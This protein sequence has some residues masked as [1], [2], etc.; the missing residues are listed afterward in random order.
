MGKNASDTEGAIIEAVVYGFLL[1]LIC[2][3]TSGYCCWKYCNKPKIIHTLKRATK[4]EAGTVF[5]FTGDDGKD[6]KLDDRHTVN[7]LLEEGG[8]EYLSPNSN[9]S[10]VSSS[11]ML[12]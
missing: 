7:P 9:H 1:L 3:C 6:K 10:H 11:K 12:S 8:H 4:R 5:V 2:I